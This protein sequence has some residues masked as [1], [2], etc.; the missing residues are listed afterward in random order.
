[1]KFTSKNLEKHIR[2]RQGYG[3][4]V[5]AYKYDYKSDTIEKSKNF[6]Y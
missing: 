5:D 6:V 2:F 4:G 3:F 1:M